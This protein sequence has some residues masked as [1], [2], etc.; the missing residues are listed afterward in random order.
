MCVGCAV[1]G[2]KGTGNYEEKLSEMNSEAYN[3]QK[4]NNINYGE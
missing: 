4:Y 3:A 2:S 1:L